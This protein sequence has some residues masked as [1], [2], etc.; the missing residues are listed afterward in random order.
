MEEDCM[1]KRT[2][3]VHRIIQL[4]RA[5]LKKERASLDLKEFPEIGKLLKVINDCQWVVPLIP[6]SPIRKKRK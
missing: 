2:R 6:P 1:A 3:K 4:D 5:A